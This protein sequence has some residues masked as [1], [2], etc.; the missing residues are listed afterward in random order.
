MQLSGFDL[1]DI[2]EDVQIRRIASFKKSKHVF[3]QALGKSEW[4]GKP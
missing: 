3:N 1:E 4:D 2:W